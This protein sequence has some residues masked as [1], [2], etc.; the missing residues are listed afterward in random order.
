MLSVKRSENILLKAKGVIIIDGNFCDSETGEI[1]CLSDICHE[2]FGESEF[3]IS[4]TKKS[5]KDV[6]PIEE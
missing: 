3:D 2:C 4:I 5:D 6:T 1:I